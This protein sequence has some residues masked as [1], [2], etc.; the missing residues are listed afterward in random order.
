MVKAKLGPG[1]TVRV[2][3]TTSGN[4][5]VSAFGGREGVILGINDGEPF[6]ITVV[7]EPIVGGGLHT[8]QIFNW[9]ELVLVRKAQKDGLKVGSGVMVRKDSPLVG[10]YPGH[11]KIISKSKRKGFD[12]AV[13][14]GGRVQSF[15]AHELMPV[16]TTLAVLTSLKKGTKTVTGKK[17]PPC[18]TGNVYVFDIGKI[19]IHGG[20]STRQAVLEPGWVAIDMREGYA[21]TLT[22][23]TTA[24]KLGGFDPKYIGQY[25]EGTTLSPYIRIPTKDGEC[26]YLP[27]QFWLDLIEELKCLAANDDLNVLVY[28]TGGHG[29]TGM[30]LSILAGLSQKVDDP[31]KFVRDK[32]CDGAVES[33][34]QKD[35]I[36]LMTGCQS[37]EQVYGWQQGWTGG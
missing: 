21:K 30:A 3:P 10:A 1:D 22:A 16:V 9:N 18:H 29:R 24:I 27:K 25:R 32:Y 6:P 14:F 34:M 19:H 28:C 13:S 11:G 15:Y 36:E 17:A 20:G 4:S 26:P 35:Y 33:Q 37:Q 31:I 2:T 12:W 8:S 7:M 5:D 23:Q